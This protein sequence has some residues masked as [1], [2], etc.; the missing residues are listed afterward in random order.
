M[1]QIATR[2]TKY[3]L[4]LNDWNRFALKHSKL[5]RSIQILKTRFFKLK[6]DD[7]MNMLR[8]LQPWMTADDMLAILQSETQHN[9]PC[10][11]CQSYSPGRNEIWLCHI[12]IKVYLM[13]Y[14][15]VDLHGCFDQVNRA[16]RGHSCNSCDWL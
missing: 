4:M 15:V 10:N 2:Y 11:G 16:M 9:T 13:S 5:K 12:A 3:Q 1:G 7:F 6:M 14:F 8:N